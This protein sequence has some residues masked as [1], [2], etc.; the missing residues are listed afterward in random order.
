MS[1]ISFNCL[2]SLCNF[3]FLKSDDLHKSSLNQKRSDRSQ[4]SGKH[5]ATEIHDYQNENPKV[6]KLSALES[7]KDLETP[8]KV[9]KKECTV[10]E[11]D[12]RIMQILKSGKNWKTYL[13]KKENED[14]VYAM[15]L[16]GRKRMAKCCIS[17]Q[18][19]MEKEILEKSKHPFIPK[20]AWSFENE[21]KV[22]LV[23]EYV[24]GGS[25]LRHILKY[26]SRFSEEITR[27]YSAEVLLTIE[28]LHTELQVAYNDIHLR[29]FLLDPKGHIKL[30]DFCQ[31]KRLSSHNSLK[32]TPMS[33]PTLRAS[34][35]T[36]E[37]MNDF[38]GLGCLM[39]ELLTGKKPYSEGDGDQE[40]EDVSPT[41]QLSWPSCVSKNA[42]DLITRLLTPNMSERLG[43]HGIDEIKKHPFFS[44]TNWE[45]ML[46]K[47]VY[48]PLVPSQFKD[49]HKDFEDDDD[50]GLDNLRTSDDVH[51]VSLD[52]IIEGSSLMHSDE[53]IDAISFD[54][55][56][57][58]TITNSILGH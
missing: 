16:I 32:E 13:V 36:F 56:T 39:Y 25:S 6:R 58:M 17:D 14:K 10:T 29:N 40:N 50:D 15:K 5:S 7:K 30:I 12:F 21:K 11:K 52:R 57:G 46:N 43:Y 3:G 20:L 28:Y 34:D 51:H 41:S 31:A 49:E 9:E 44:Q 42:K 35:P 22:F 8:A 23:M 55:T 38:W 47:S 2:Q 4:R 26:L 54:R 19:T 48:P 18:M 1:K 37:Q 33:S 27:F 45:K 24:E 53:D